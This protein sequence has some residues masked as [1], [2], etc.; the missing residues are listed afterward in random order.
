MVE[1][2]APKSA[3]ERLAIQ[4]EVMQLI[5]LAGLARGGF[6]EKAAFYGGTCLHLFYG[7]ERFSEDMDFSLLKPD[8]SFDFESFFPAIKEEFELAGKEVEIQLKHK[9]RPSSVESA[10]LKES[11]EI[12]RIGFT[13][14]KQ[15]KVKVEV[16]LLPPPCFSTEM[17]LLVRPVSRWIRVYSTGDLYAGKVSAALFRSWRARIKGRDW[18]DLE[19]YVR[20]G[21]TCHLEHLA[22]R[23]AEVSPE[24][25]LSS[26]E[27][28]IAAFRR[29]IAT[30]D[31][32]A[33]KADVRPFLKDASCLDI[34]SKEYFNSLVDR[35]KVE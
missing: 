3:A 27:A 20:N 6:F 33:A 24:T 19:W 15:I 21:F 30:I 14:Q 18:Y 5:A 23:A 35:I 16:D 29:R 13:T 22:A 12:F 8:P 4:Q 26:R 2:Y 25:D 10:F 28:L 7:M 1:S 11:S 32:H 17:K 9:G 34:W 31:F